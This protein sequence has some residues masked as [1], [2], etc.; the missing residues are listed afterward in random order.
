M[1]FRYSHDCVTMMFVA[2]NEVL[3][4]GTERGELRPSYTAEV[5]I[6]L[7]RANDEL[8]AHQKAQEALHPMAL[9]FYE[10]LQAVDYYFSRLPSSDRPLM[11]IEGIRALL[12][13]ADKLVADAKGGAS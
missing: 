2:L 13:E 6:A 3:R 10:L 1:T 12:I 7:R 5:D 8:A 9:R 4:V 11:I